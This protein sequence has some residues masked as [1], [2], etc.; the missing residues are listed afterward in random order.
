MSHVSPHTA[1][2]DVSQMVHDFMKP[3]R[4]RRQYKLM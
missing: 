3:S 2:R 4:L 1:Y